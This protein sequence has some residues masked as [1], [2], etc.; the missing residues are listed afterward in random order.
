VNEKRGYANAVYMPW[1]SNDEDGKKSWIDLD[2]SAA[3]A[4]PWT[5]DSIILMRKGSQE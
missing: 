2:S 1:V 3:K 4:K 5:R